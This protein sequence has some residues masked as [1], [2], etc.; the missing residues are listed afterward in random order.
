MPSER[1]LFEQKFRNSI[2]LHKN[3]ETHRWDRNLFEGG[4][5]GHCIFEQKLRNSILLHKNVETHRWDRNLFE[6]A[7]PS[8]WAECSQ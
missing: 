6:R 4:V 7:F 8:F 1:N 5:S 3:V 2:L